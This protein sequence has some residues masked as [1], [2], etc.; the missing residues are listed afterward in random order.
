MGVVWIPIDFYGSL[1]IPVDF[2]EFLWNSIKIGKMCVG[3]LLEMKRNFGHG[4]IN[5][6]MWGYKTKEKKKKG[7]RG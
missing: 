7:R 5:P 6:Q 3:N 1:W 2:Y 4:N